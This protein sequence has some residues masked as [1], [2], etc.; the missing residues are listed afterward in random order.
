MADTGPKQHHYLPESYLNGFTNDRGLL[1]IYDWKMDQYREQSPHNTCKENNFNT[2]YDEDGN[3]VLAA[4]QFYSVIEGLGKPI[5][6][7]LLKG[8][9]LDGQQLSDLAY[10]VACM[11]SRIPAFREMYIKGADSLYKEILKST[12]RTE[13]DAIRFMKGD[14]T[15][16]QGLLDYIH[17][18]RFNI[19]PHQNT[20]IQSAV[21]MAEKM[22][23]IFYS[24]EWMILT[25]DPKKSFVTS[26]APLTRY[27]NSGFRPMSPFGG[28][29]VLVP[30]VEKRIALAAGIFLV[31]LDKGERT[32]YRE[33]S[34]LAVRHLNLYTAARSDRFLVARDRALLENLVKNVREQHS[35]G[36][37]VSTRFERDENGR[38]G[39]GILTQD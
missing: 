37:K 5:I 15:D 21:R 28:L 25:C 24:Q 14:A 27:A 10:F 7:D 23:E 12:V 30:G 29:G 4:E 18:E 13:E 1:W 33:I 17:N 34:H 20:V 6:D 35:H 22:H 38:G 19:V 8:K 3:R 2:I 36:Y 16:P 39:L 31:I 9:E 32:R 26:D 11:Y